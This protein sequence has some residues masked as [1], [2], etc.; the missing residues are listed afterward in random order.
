MSGNVL[1]SYIGIDIFG[2]KFCSNL[3]CSSKDNKKCLQMMNMTYK[4]I[5]EMFINIIPTICPM[6]LVSCMQT[7]PQ[8]NIQREMVKS[9]KIFVATLMDFGN[10]NCN[11]R[12][13]SLD[14]YLQL[15]LQT[16]PDFER[17]Y[18]NIR[19]SFTCL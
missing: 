5:I 2:S 6:G 8:C 11:V 10:C 7:R 1:F 16:R 14:R 13:S 15:V 12:W 17:K 18:K 3:R 4:V 19:F 9:R